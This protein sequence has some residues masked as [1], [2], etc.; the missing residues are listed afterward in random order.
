M[1]TVSQLKDGVAALLSGI[2]LNNISNLNPALERAARITIQQA[3]IPEASGT[4]SI[5]LYNKVFDYP[6][7][8]GIFGGALTDIQPQGVSRT[9]NDFVY[10]QPIELFD[11]TKCLLPNGY[12]VT[13]QPTNGTPIMRIAQTRAPQAIILDP[14]NAT[15]GWTA[16]GV[17]TGLTTDSTVYYQSPASLRFNLTGT[18]AGILTKTLA[19][20]IDLTT[21]E[22]VGVVFLAIYAPSVSALTNI[23][24]KIGS[25]SSNYSLVTATA[26][27]LGAFQANE[28]ALVAFDLANA[29]NT[30][31][32]D[33]SAIQYVQVTENVTGAIANFRV[34]NLFIALPSPHNILY[35]SSAIFSVNGALSQT[36]TTDNDIIILNDAAYTLYEHE[37]ALTIALQ[38]GGKLSG[39]LV[40]F[41]RAIL[42]G[43]GSDPGL[44]ARYRGDNPSQELRTIGSYYSVNGL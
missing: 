25:D 5:M 10:K 41:L 3:D 20:P 7:P 4:Q 31:T 11:R 44:Y 38:S 42:Y 15:T 13:F 28:F 26:A 30:G 2:N 14:M 19:N 40:Q 21:Y 18:G 33:F 22:G 37:C 34:G 9:V 8:S 27:F 17:A 16:S 35:E 24:V 39:P 36:I 29:T 43:S 23:Q 6:A 12:Q 1:H 32:P